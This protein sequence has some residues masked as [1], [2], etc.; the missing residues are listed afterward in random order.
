MDQDLIDSLKRK[1]LKDCKHFNGMANTACSVGVSYASVCDDQGTA[2][3][4]PC[5]PTVGG[6]KCRT[7]CAKHELP[8]EDEAVK[9]AENVAKT[10]YKQ[11]PSDA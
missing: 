8:T 5:L 11:T 10:F 7:T 9:K 3:L 1:F 4:Y 2:R 6:A